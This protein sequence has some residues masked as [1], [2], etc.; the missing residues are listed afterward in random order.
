MPA[1]FP[2]RD[3]PVIPAPRTPRPL[4]HLL[5]AALPLVLLLAS[6]GP[7]EE[8]RARQEAYVRYCAAC[9]G[10]EGEGMTGMPIAPVLASDDL[11]ALADDAFLA[12]TIARGRPGENGRDKPGT[13]MSPLGADY[14]GP[15]TDGDIDGIVAHMRSW[16]VGESEVLDASFVAE[17]DLDAGRE[18]YE[19]LCAACHG[20]DGWGEL[21]PRLAGEVF[22]ETA[23]DDFI[24]RTVR[25][26]RAG[27]TMP[28]Y[29]EAALDDTTLEAIIAYV[30][31]LY[32]EDAS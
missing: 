7:T 24:R 10:D 25:R 30:R 31:S 13:K 12:E 22:Q 8:E 17:G 26:G 11:L 2:M 32:D 29:G 28:A 1:T 27:T 15:L 23:S 20:E 5:L 19:T 4:R 18:A 6:C 14:R 21:A 3:E 16:Q 9:H